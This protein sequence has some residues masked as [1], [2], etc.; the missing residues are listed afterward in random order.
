[1]KSCAHCGPERGPLP[2]SEFH[3]NAHHADGL[4]SDCKSCRRKYRKRHRAEHKERLDAEDAAYR[5]QIRD[6]VFG[7]YGRVCA[8]C[9]AS[10]DMTI[11]HPGGD[12]AAH[13][14][15]LFGVERSGTGH[16]FYLWLIREGFPDGYQ[17]LCRPCNSSKWTGEHCR[18]HQVT[19]AA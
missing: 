9:G 4:A 16:Q 14:V 2:D 8:C 1:M 12:G 5:E 13:R 6:Q 19:E 17:A 11:D 7:H 3:K 15:E 18:I 10:E